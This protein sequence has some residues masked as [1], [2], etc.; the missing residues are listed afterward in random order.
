MK[1]IYTTSQTP[2]RGQTLRRTVFSIVGAV[3]LA[4]SGGAVLVNLPQVER[5]VPG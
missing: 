5:L 1:R 4:V 3:S 2:T